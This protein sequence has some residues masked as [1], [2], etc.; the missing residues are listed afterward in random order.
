VF[1]PVTKRVQL[2]LVACQD[3]GD[4]PCSPDGTLDLSGFQARGVSEY[5]EYLPAG[6]VEARIT[7]Q[8]LAE[9][10]RDL[11][12]RYLFVVAPDAIATATPFAAAADDGGDD[13]ALVWAPTPTPT[14][15]PEVP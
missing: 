10:P 14:A 2:E 5:L 3:G 1:R 6:P 13:A 11:D 12:F 8:N 15:T 4:R 9:P 7:A